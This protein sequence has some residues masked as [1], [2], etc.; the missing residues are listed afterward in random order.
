VRQSTMFCRLLGLVKTVVLGVR[1]EEDGEQTRL[2]VRVRPR[3]KASG[4]CGLCHRK[5]PGY[6]RGGGLRRWR[7]L[8]LADRLCFLE[9]EAPRVRCPLDGVVVAAVP[10]ARHGADFTHAFEDQVAWLA[11]HCSQ[12]AVAELMR[13]SW[14]TVGSI[15]RRVVTD[16]RA[17]S[18]YLRNVTRIGIDEVHYKRGQRYLTVI[19]D[20]DTGH[21]LYA[22]PGRDSETIGNFFLLLGREGCARITLVS[23]DA[24]E[25]IAKAVRAHCPNAH[26]CLD[27]FHVVSWVTDALDE[28]RRTVW[29]E[30]R[31][32][33]QTEFAKEI[34]G[35]RWALW[36]NPPQLS[37]RE[38]AKLAE[39]QRTNGPLYRAYLLK[40]QLRQ[41]FQVPPSDALRLLDAWLAWACRSRLD[42]FVRVARTIR[43]LR[44]EIADAIRYGLSNARV[45]AAN[46]KIRVLTRVA[47]G[48]HS[49]E[50]LVSLVYLTL[51]GCCPPLPGR[52]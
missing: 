13:I 46:T 37:Q 24:G 25:W 29:N 26:L 14:Y 18:D 17:R 27:P 49:A 32:Q 33:G 50:A 44:N 7:A 15:I 10:W 48:F 30:A 41:V 36:K 35:A 45:E 42:P 21:I 34:K 9:A 16:A 28:V 51:G 43:G 23:A 40:E 11:A 8:D 20:H 22:A 19:L 38:Q 39:I 12:T 1:L 52:A 47:Y 4:R 3:R 2:V 6:D 5:C 31:R